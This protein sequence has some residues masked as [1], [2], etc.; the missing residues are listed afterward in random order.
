MAAIL[1]NVQRLQAAKAYA[2]H[3][4]DKHWCTL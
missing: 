2:K 1:P 4:S 3:S